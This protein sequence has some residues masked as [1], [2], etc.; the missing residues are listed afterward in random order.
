MTSYEKIISN[1]TVT[2]KSYNEDDDI[3]VSPTGSSSGDGTINLP[4]DIDTAIDFVK[5]GQHIIVLE[6]RYVRKSPLEI[7][8][9]NDGKASAKKYIEAAPGARPIFDFDKKTEGVLLSG[10]YWHVKGLDFTRSAG[11]TKGFTV[12][13]NYNIVENSRFYAN[14]D[15]GLQISRTDGTAIEINEW[16]SYNL[17]L[18]S[19][20]FDNRDPSDNNADGF[21]AKLTAGVGNIFRGCLA[22]NNIDDGWDLYTKAGSGA[23]GSV[24]IEHSAA[25]NNGFLTDGTVG[26]GDKN[27]FKLGGEGIHV[28]H[29]IRDS[30][31]FGNGAYGFTSNSNPGVIAINNIGF[32]NTRG[33]ISFTTYDHIT[34]DFT[35]DGFLSYRTANIAKTN[36]QLL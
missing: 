30:I 26:A 14:G 19:T 29:T 33:N 15:T 35:I 24:L 5:P 31:A 25:F 28:T 17:I 20:S 23:I 18:N 8:K 32:N 2:L 11:N 34:A 7:K 13:G 36:I 27:G 3:Y 9:Y 4:L 21:A 6:G 22:H 12:G 16:P 10:N 1:F